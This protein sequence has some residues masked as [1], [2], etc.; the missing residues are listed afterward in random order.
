M[1]NPAGSGRGKLDNKCYKNGYWPGSVLPITPIAPNNAPGLVSS[2]EPS[3]VK[4]SHCFYLVKF[5]SPPFD[6]EKILLK[7]RNRDHLRGLISAQTTPNELPE[8]LHK[9]ELS[10]SPSNE[11]HAFFC[12]QFTPRHNRND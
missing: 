12:V 1:A 3:Q 2:I 10:R 4:S 8:L 9:S 11:R 7:G 6:T 5:I